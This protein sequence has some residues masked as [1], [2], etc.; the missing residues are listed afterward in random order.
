MML[1]LSTAVSARHKYV[2]HIGPTISLT[3]DGGTIEFEIPV[4]DRYDSK[5]FE[6]YMQH[7]YNSLKK[8]PPAGS[9]IKIKNPGFP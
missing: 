6:H 7:L 8:K 5:N 2:H 9:T 1:E 4:W 3:N